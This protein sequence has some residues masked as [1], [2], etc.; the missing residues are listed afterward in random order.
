MQRHQE[1]ER[2][3]H[4]R[5]SRTIWNRF[6]GAVKQYQLLSPGDRVAVCLSGG[7]DSALLAKCMQQLQKHS[8]FPF[9]L[10]FLVMDPGYH[11]ENRRLILDNAALLDIPVQV[12][13]TRIFDIVYKIEDNPCYLCAKMR[14][15]HLYANAKEAGCNKIAL[16]HHFDD[17]IETVLMSILYGSQVRTMMPKLHSQNYEGMQLIRPLYLVR[18]A[19]IL[20]WRDYNGLHFL[21]C[22]C[23]F[24][25]DSAQ[26]VHSS[27]RSEVKALIARLKKENPQVDINI[28]RSL[29]N[30]DLKAV[31]GY[32]LDGVQHSFLEDYDRQA[33]HPGGR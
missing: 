11:P 10:V 22:A 13:D 1:I 16:G 15:G 12:F 19:D 2:S 31:I 30:I 32:T 8:D 9:E 29:H 24:T 18:E 33:P 25:A 21:Q 26:S 17:V 28:F 14:R 23:R 3:L 7:K 20:R 4:K 6:V 5:F 27:K